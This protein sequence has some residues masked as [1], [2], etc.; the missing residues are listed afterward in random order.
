MLKTLATFILI[1]CCAF[2]IYNSISSIIQ[3]KKLK[4][5]ITKVEPEK[6][7]DEEVKENKE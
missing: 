6:K 3:K 4:K 7:E 1:G 5:T 2:V